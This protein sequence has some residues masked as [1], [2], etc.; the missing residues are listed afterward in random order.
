MN[1]K[2]QRVGI[3]IIFLVYLCVGLSVFR[4]YGASFDENIN[5]DLGIRTLQYVK[6]K[7]TG[8]RAPSD[9]FFSGTISE[10]GPVFETFLVALESV[11]GLTDS[12][13]ILLLRHLGDFVVFWLGSI[14][15]YVLMKL[16]FNDRIIALFGAAAFVLTPR[17]F[18]HAFYNSV[19]TVLAAFFIIGTL[20][21]VRLLREMT[22][23]IVVLHALVCA[24]AT[25]IRVIG[26]LLS[27][28]TVLFILFDVFQARLEMRSCKQNLSRAAVFVLLF[29][30]FVLL[31]WPQ[32]WDDPFAN[33]LETVGRL[34]AANQL[35]YPYSLY[36]GSF[37]PVDQLPWHYLPV[38]MLV[39]IPLPL[40]VL[41]VLGIWAVARSL[42]K[43][44]FMTN[45]NKLNVLFVLLL[46][47]PLLAV[48]I[49][50][51]ILYDDWRHFYFMYP[52]FLA[53][54][55][56]G[57][58]ELRQRVRLHRLIAVTIFF[59]IAHG[60]IVIVHYHPYQGVYFNSLAGS[61]IDKN[62]ELD[63]WGLSF[64]EG[65]ESIL[66]IDK[67]VPIL[68]TVDHP[69]YLNCALLEPWKRN[70]FKFVPLQ[71]A[72]YFLSN[73]R[74]PDE[75]RNYSNNWYPYTNE[76]YAV[77]INGATLLGVYKLK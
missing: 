31:L 53:I 29:C 32:L 60:I 7:L 76:V 33:L 22:W 18:A 67:E 38:W 37:V 68:I 43:Y 47:V 63:Y 57:L 46:L 66:R 24:I 23:S 6:A 21:L 11:S 55:L 20:T 5:R 62:W 35:V 65:L 14:A 41:F 54:G 8:D 19:D 58:H 42:I 36:M 2:Y 1:A 4:D 49:L 52:A 70:R 72:K 51:P 71:D 61:Q 34:R 59:I 25:S 69:G 73:H 40:T 74:Q 45:E 15:F 50:K 28:L 77:R 9:Q 56:T 12:R 13:S 3:A 10:K 30:I 48:C 17:M 44:P 16:R 64:K 26:L 27:G 39:T 75:Y